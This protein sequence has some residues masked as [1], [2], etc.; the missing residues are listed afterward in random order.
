MI[1]PKHGHWLIIFSV[2]LAVVLTSCAGNKQPQLEGQRISQMPARLTV[3]NQFGASVQIYFRPDFGGETY[4]GR[5]STGETKTLLIRPPFPSGHS[6]LVALPAPA[7]IAGEPIIA[8][9]VQE[10]EPGDTLR[11]DLQLKTLDWRARGEAK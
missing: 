10:L 6:R 3:V 2:T 4:L 1:I 11:W 8:E 5:V 7:A 9:L